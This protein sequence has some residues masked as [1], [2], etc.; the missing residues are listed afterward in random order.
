MGGWSG[1]VKW[2]G[3]SGRVKVG[4]EGFPV[5]ESRERVGCEWLD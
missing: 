1:R 3:V 5:R 2:E 4:V